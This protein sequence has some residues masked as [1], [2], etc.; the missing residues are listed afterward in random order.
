MKNI[1]SFFGNQEKNQTDNKCLRICEPCGAC[2][3]S[4]FL[5]DATIGCLVFISLQYGMP[6]NSSSSGSSSRGHDGKGGENAWLQCPLVAAGSNLR[7]G[8]LKRSLQRER[9]EEK[10]RA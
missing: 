7:C 10:E 8:N 2:S 9:E 4:P 6:H 1:F 5:S 3:L